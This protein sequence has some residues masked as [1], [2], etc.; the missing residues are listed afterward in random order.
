YLG[1]NI[2]FG[3][4]RFAQACN[5]MGISRSQIARGNQAALQP[6]VGFLQAF[7]PDLAQTLVELQQL[8]FAVGCP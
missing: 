3:N 7:G 2:Q 5:E 1:G 8:K 4:Y 6:P